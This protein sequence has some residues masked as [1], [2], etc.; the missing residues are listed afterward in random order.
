[1]IKFLF[2]LLPPVIEDK[3]SFIGI[4][5]VK[6][7]DE[8]NMGVELRMTKDLLLQASHADQEKPYVHPTVEIP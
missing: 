1:M 5:L 7:M 8:A 6:L 4:Q 3:F 2:H